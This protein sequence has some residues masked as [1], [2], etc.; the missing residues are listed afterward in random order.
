MCLVLLADIERA[1][2]KYKKRELTA[3]LI[4]SL[5]REPKATHYCT[6]AALTQGASGHCI[7]SIANFD[8]HSNWM[9]GPRPQLI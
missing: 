3:L 9:G 6:D 2:G 7:I 5:L 4:K 8:K 1:R